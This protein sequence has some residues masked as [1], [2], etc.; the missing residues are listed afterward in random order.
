[1]TAALGLYMHLKL[2]EPWLPTISSTPLIV[3]GAAGAVGAYAVKLAQV[4]NIHP[5]I[6]V[7]GNGIPYVETLISPEK[8]DAVV[9]YRKGNEA[10]VSGIGEALEKAGVSEVKY[11]V[12]AV[13]KKDSYQNIS[14]V[15]SKGGKIFLVLPGKDHTVIQN[16]IEQISGSVGIVHQAVSPDSTEGKAGIKTNAKD[17]GYVFFRLLSR[18]LQEGWFT[19]HPYQVIPGGLNRLEEGLRNLMAGKASAVKYVYKIADTK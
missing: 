11:A 14:E 2:P 12:D 7:A 15:L 17:F 19:P 6:A 16:Y 18:G 4:S 3:Y 8:G 13:S 10:V 9:D 1:M 5:I